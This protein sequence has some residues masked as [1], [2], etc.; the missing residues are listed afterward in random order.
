MSRVNPY[1]SI[2]KRTF[3]AALLHLLETEYELV[4]S[5]RILKVMIEDIEGLIEQF[6]PQTER[7]QSGQ[8][9]WACTGDEGQKA[10]PG[11]PTEA[12][13][14]VTV[15]L[16]LIEDEDLHE[17]TERCGVGRGQGRVRERHK[18]Q[19]QRM[20]GAAAEQGGLLTLAELSV[21][22]GVGYALVQRYVREIEQDTGRPLPLKG[23]KMDQG[24]RPTHK[25]E[26][27]RLFEQGQSPPDI[28]RASGHN[29]KSVERYL[30]D[31]E[32]VLM[33]LKQKLSI[34]AISA[35]IERGP[36]VV[37]E[38]VALARQFH[39]DLFEDEEKDS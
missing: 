22:L 16:P 12:Y 36:S 34:E 25:A 28:A 10:Q 8:L 31:Y 18:R 3:G 39:P 17:R 37:R 23:Y 13:K 5:R 21:L 20:V 9:V 14:T 33:L 4:G 7:V 19:I 26:I 32:R 15:V 29:L 27:V 30:K 35:M 38:Y 1:A 2:E 24:S 11:K 6:Y